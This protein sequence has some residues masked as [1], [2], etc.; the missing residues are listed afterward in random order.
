MSKKD[1]KYKSKINTCGADYGSDEAN[2]HMDNLLKVKTTEDMEEWMKLADEMKIPSMPIKRFK[3]LEE[4][5][6]Y[7]EDKDYH[8]KDEGDD[9]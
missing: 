5:E 3:T 8:G 1:R 6:K 2:F 4:A 7:N 9:T